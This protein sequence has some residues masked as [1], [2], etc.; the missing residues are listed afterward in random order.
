MSELEGTM[1]RNVTSVLLTDR[2]KPIE[3]TGAY[4]WAN[5][6]LTVY[7]NNDQN[8]GR[9]FPPDAIREVKFGKENT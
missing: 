6:W 5:G 8:Q 2:E 4:M 7:T 9:I 1:L 3:T